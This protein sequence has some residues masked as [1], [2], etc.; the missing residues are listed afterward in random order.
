MDC[1]TSV[2]QS[3]DQERL[4]FEICEELPVNR[5]PDHKQTCLPT[6]LVTEGVFL[7]QWNTQC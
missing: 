6:K 4:C 1:T 3:E 2:E 5:K 7:M